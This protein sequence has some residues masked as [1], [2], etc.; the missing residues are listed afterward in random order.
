M[1]F[2]GVYFPL[3]VKDST[4]WAAGLDADIYLME[5]SSWIDTD[6]AMVEVACTIWNP[7]NNLQGNV[8]HTV[9]FTNAGLVN[10]MRPEFTV[11]AYRQVPVDSSRRLTVLNDALPEFLYNGL[12]LG[13]RCLLSLTGICMK[14]SGQLHRIK[15]RPYSSLCSTGWQNSCKI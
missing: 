8:L 3:F 9:E 13:M 2:D 6:T 7:N 1:F 15:F 11:G 12:Q 10:P 5:N 4:T 14:W